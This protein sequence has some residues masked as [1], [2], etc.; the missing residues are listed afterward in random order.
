[1]GDCQVGDGLCLPI[2]HYLREVL[3]TVEQIARLLLGLPKQSVLVVE[4]HAGCDEHENLERTAARAR[5][6][7]STFFHF[8]CELCFFPFSDLNYSLIIILL[9]KHVSNLMELF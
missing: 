9:F 5:Q 4:H 1:M 7:K 6:G 3:Q 8:Q 2:L